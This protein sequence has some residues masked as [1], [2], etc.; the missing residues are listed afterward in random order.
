MKKTAQD[1]TRPSTVRAKKIICRLEKHPN[2]YQ[3][4]EENK[5]PLLTGKTISQGDRLGDEVGYDVALIQPDSDD[6]NNSS[7]A[8]LENSTLVLPEE[9]LHQQQMDVSGGCKKAAANGD[10]RIVQCDIIQE[11]IFIVQLENVKIISSSKLIDLQVEN[12]NSEENASGNW[13]LITYKKTLGSRIGSLA[14]QNNS[15]SWKKGANEG[16]DPNLILSTQNIFEPLSATENI[17]QQHYIEKHMTSVSQANVTN[18]L[19]ITKEAQRE[20]NASR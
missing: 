11:K 20:M 1:R 17:Q 2:R 3:G 4:H 9:I 12:S 15:S 13:N 7:I 10:K 16:S 19:I 8:P 6:P 14:G 18:E 5:C